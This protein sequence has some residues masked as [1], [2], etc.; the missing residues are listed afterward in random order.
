MCKWN[1]V[2]TIW[3]YKVEEEI[4][5][6]VRERKRLNIT[7]PDWLSQY[8]LPNLKLNTTFCT[9]CPVQNSKLN[10]SS[11]TCCPIQNSEFKTTS[12]TCCPIRNCNFKT[13]SSCT[14]CPIQNSKLNT[15]SCTCCPI[16]NSKL[17]KTSCTCCPI[18]NSKFKTTSSCTC[19]PIQNSL[20]HKH[21]FKLLHFQWNF[22]RLLQIHDAPI[23]SLKVGTEDN[24]DPSLGCLH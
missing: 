5:L 23:C 9:C 3:G 15:N 22:T 4:Y 1:N 20:S 10:T 7:G 6:G 2:P 19:C 8:L 14:F 18:R 24:Q 17:N 16:Q 21:R 13:V 12:C 11:C